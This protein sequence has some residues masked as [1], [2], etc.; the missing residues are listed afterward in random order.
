[1]TQRSHYQFHTDTKNILFESAFFLPNTVRSLS[2]KYRIQTDSS[3]RFERGVDYKLQEFALSRIHF[4]LSSYISIG[5]CNLNKISHKSPLTKTNSFKFDYK[6]FK[7]ILGIELQSNKV[8]AIL[9][10]LGFIFKSDK[11]IVPSF[12]FDVT[13]NY[14]LVEEVSRII[15]YDNIPELPLSIKISS[16]NKRYTFQ[17]R[18][19]TQTLQTLQMRGFMLTTILLVYTLFPPN[20]QFWKK[21][22][23]PL[24]LGLE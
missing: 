9:S 23:L 17:N 6:L 11:V 1:M 7:R 22:M 24:G 21:V 2:T 18:L 4:I 20:Y 5:K 15:G 16:T 19:I 8:K 3:Y 13:S 10:N 12:R 14:D